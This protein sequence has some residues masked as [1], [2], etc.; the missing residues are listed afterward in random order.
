MSLL[1]TT[2]KMAALA[3]LELTPEE[4]D[5]YSSQIEDVLGYVHSLEQVDVHGV[6]PL[7]HPHQDRLAE[8][9][10]REDV[11]SEKAP[12]VEPRILGCAPEVL[13]SGFKVPS[14]L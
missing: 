1:E 9:P 8:T 5:R 14:I 11:A 3:R 12:S 13:E 10:S 6:E 4:L 2:R 7:T